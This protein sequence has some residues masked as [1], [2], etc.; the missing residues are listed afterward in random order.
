MTIEEAKLFFPYSENDDLF[1][2]YDERLFE[3]KQFFLSKTP[4]RKVF[5]AKLEK[6]TQMNQAY[7]MITGNQDVLSD[8]E[9]NETIDFSDTIRIAFNQWEEL[10]GKS[11]QLIMHSKNAFSLRENVL[12]Y[13]NVVDE[14]RLKWYTGIDIDSEIPQLSKEED[15][16]DVLAEIKSFEQEGGVYFEDILKLGTN[17]FLLKEM[18]RLSLLVKKYGNGRS[19]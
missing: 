12:Y 8:A 2:L 11:K 16:M 13:L 15:P 7:E 18:K 6:L 4:I 1:D 10:K 3:Y 9:P 14:Y 5:E 19:I 17:S